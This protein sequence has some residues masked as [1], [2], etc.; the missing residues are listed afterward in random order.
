VP[1]AATGALAGTGGL[2]AG[3]PAGQWVRAHTLATD[4]FITVGPSFANVIQF[5]GGRK[6]RALSVSTN[7]LRRNPTY[8]PVPN[9]DAS[10]RSGTVKYLVY[11]AYS[12][13]RSPFFARKLLSYAKKFSAAPVYEYR[14]PAA[15]N[16][17]ERSGAIVVVIYA[18]YP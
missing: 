13:A 15:S 17:H 11:D 8:E 6:A 4:E 14:Q 18:V 9:P 10:I 1:L 2:A 16:R 3:R 7:P 5:Y 12:A